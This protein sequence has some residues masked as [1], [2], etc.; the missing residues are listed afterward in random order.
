[1]RSVKAPLEFVD[2][3]ELKTTF[4]LLCDEGSFFRLTL[5]VFSVS[6][7]KKPMIQVA[8]FYTAEEETQQL[9]Q[10]YCARAVKYI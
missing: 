6:A 4:S 8:S 9:S 5:T 2:D 10:R 1:V 3:E 7:D